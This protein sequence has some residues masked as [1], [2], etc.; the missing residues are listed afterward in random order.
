MYHHK[1]FMYNY[2]RILH[3]K[4]RGKSRLK[5]EMMG[6]YEQQNNLPITI[7]KIPPFKHAYIM[8]VEYERRFHILMFILELKENMFV[9]VSMKIPVNIH[10]DL[11][12]IY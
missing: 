6:Y 2:E 4:F 11:H 12:L 5:K 3:E 1:Y 9:N 10:L 7:K 8:D